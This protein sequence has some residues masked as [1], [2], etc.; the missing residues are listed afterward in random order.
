MLFLL[1]LALLKVRRRIHGMLEIV[2]GPSKTIHK[3]NSVYSLL[4][5]LDGEGAGNYTVDDCHQTDNVFFCEDPSQRLV[6]G[7]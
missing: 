2:V 5:I 6:L 3:R 7:R 4:V 1:S